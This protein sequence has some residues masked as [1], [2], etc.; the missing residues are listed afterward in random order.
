MADDRSRELKFGRRL[1]WRF[2]MPKL[3]G[4]LVIRMFLLLLPLSSAPLLISA[5][6]TL[7][8]TCPRHDME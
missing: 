3:G 1:L 6:D 5:E 8:S 7:L 2:I 4:L